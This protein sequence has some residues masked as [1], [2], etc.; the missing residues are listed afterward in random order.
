VAAAPE[1]PIA[2]LLR[3]RAVKPALTFKASAMAEAPDDLMLLPPSLRVVSTW[4]TLRASAIASMPAA[5]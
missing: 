3:L 2:S 1:G 5:V 4:L